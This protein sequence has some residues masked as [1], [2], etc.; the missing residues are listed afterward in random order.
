MIRAFEARRTSARAMRDATITEA[1]CRI[2]ADNYACYGVRKRWRAINRDG[3]CGHVARCTVEHLMRDAGI[4]GVRR[5][6]KKP[7]TRSA[8]AADCPADLVDRAFRADDMDGLIHHSDRGVRYRA[9]HY[10]ATRGRQRRRR[11]VGLRVTR[12]TM[13]W[14]RRSIRCTKPS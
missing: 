14:L 4:D 3:S 8:D 9:V 11:L 1:L 13:R 6:R 7:S 5:K 2:H 12:M 10:T